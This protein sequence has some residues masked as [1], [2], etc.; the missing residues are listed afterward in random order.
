MEAL[1]TQVHSSP[2]LMK[3]ILS[4]LYLDICIL[5]TLTL[6]IDQAL[7]LEIQVS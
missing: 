3:L 1:I 4:A 7:T 2:H 6:V 5:R